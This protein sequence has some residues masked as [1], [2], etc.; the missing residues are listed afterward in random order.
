[1]RFFGKFHTDA[2]F[3]AVPAL[4]IAPWGERLIRYRKRCF[5]IFIASAFTSSIAPTHLFSQTERDSAGARVAAAGHRVHSSATVLPLHNGLNRVDLLGAGQPGEIIVSRRGNG[6]A[7]GFGIVLFQ[8]LASTSSDDSNKRAWQV[9][10]FFG[11]PYDSETGEELF[12]T[13]EG[14]DT[15]RFATCASSAAA[16]G[17]QWRS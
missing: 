16:R 4:R 6:N 10:P 7:H 12:R 11:G 8:V 3:P 9:I 1:V 2:I 17:N 14:A 13:S 5:A 15:V